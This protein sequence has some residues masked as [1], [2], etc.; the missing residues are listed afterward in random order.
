MKGIVGFKLFIN[1]IEGKWKL[2][3]NHS[4]DRQESVI[5][6]LEQIPTDNAR[7]IA[8][9]MKNNNREGG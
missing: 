8:R 2:S 3:Q 6:N 7:E 1:N 5:A 4:I 9:L